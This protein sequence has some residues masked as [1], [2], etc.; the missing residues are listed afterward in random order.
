MHKEAIVQLLEAN[1]TA[2][3][4][5]LE[6]QDKDHW[7]SGP[8]GKWTTGQVALHLLQS[9]KPVNDAMSM[10]KF[11]LRYK[12]GKSNREVRD[13][14][15]V[16][17]RYQDKL[18]GAQ[19]LVSPFSRDMKPV[20]FSDK[21]YLLTRLQMENKK[22]QYKTKKWKDSHLDSYVLPHPLLGK[23]P[24]REVVMWTAY[25]VLHHTQQLQTRY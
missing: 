15:T 14:N 5:W 1:H 10:P 25:H 11:I 17:A 22:L 7:E 4:D 12:F 6:Q 20:Q 23:M 21:N 18:K 24:L 9:I 3:L 8:E 16:V 2:L 19:G 13:Y